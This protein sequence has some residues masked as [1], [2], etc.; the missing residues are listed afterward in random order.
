MVFDD[1][2]FDYD[3]HGRLESKRI[4]NH[5]EQSFS[6]DGEHRLRQ[7]ETIRNGTRQLVYFEY[8]ALGRRLRKND[9]FGKTQFLWD[10]LL[11]VQEQ[12]G[13][14]VAT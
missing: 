10:D 3:V 1:K 13:S 2:R 11:M 14:D 7:V 5:I 8:D 4:G 9:A 12:R 6:Y